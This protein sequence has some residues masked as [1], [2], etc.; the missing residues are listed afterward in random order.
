MPKEVFLAS[1]RGGT[2]LAHAEDEMHLTGDPGIMALG[3]R[4]NVAGALSPEGEYSTFSLDA[5]GR[6]LVNAQ[7][8]ITAG[9]ASE[10]HL[11]EISGPTLVS[12]ATFVRPADVIPYSLGDAVMQSTTAPNALVFAGMARVAGGYGSIVHAKAMVSGMPTTI[13]AFDLHLFSGSFVPDGDNVPFGPNWDGVKLQVAQ[14]TFD[15]GGTHVY[16]TLYDEQNL[17]ATYQCAAGQTTLWGI[18][19]ARTAY[20]PASGGT[21]VF[22]LG[23]FPT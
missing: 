10:L 1:N 21:I 16:H 11:G 18:P 17:S 2:Q 4:Q 9:G 14:I 22:E 3:V 13:P 6:V 12:R 20:T 7:G 5:N 15:G 19:E 23:V 8:T